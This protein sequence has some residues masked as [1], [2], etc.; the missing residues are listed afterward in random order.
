M[1]NKTNKSEEKSM[2]MEIFNN[3]VNAIRNKNIDEALADYDT[4]VVS[5]DVIN[6][7]Q[8]N[9]IE[10]VKG[11]LE[12]WFSSFKESIGFEVKNIRI[13]ADK[14]IAFCFCLNHVNAIT[15]KGESLNMWWRETSCLKKI[16][17]KWKFVH[18]HSSVPFNPETG[19]A[20]TDL[21]P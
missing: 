2:I 5:F 7:L 6:P 11:R 13:E 17:D 10:E 1:K 8:Y 12:N 19:Y 3:R 20:S 15:N 21:K 16:N 4:N 9:G 18:V 14:E